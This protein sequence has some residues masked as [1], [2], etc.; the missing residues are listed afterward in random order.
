[1]EPIRIPKR[2]RFP[3]VD[4]RICLAFLSCGRYDL[5]ERSLA[6]VV[7]HMEQYEP[8]LAY[9]V[10]LVD[11]CNQDAGSEFVERISQRFQIER[12][13]ILRTN[14]GIAAG[15]NT[16]YFGLCRAPYILSGE[17]DWVW[18]PDRSGDKS[19]MTAAVEALDSD[20]VLIGVILREARSEVNTS[21]TKLKS[22]AEYRYLQNPSNEAIVIFVNG[23]IVL[24][25]KNLE[26][27]GKMEPESR[28]DRDVSEENYKMRTLANGFKSGIIKL[29]EQDECDRWPQE[30]YSTDC[31]SV[32]RHI[33]G[34]RRIQQ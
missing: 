14:Y 12:I 25:K 10:A 28:L 9:E 31:H 15:L 19:I 27:V 18:R 7:D 4:P 1:V 32:M 3:Q 24:S 20:P 5:L 23:G 6:S 16:L 22:G 17:D 11:N 33:G 2:K 30:M 13:S 26:T 29:I 34:G 8:G 21:W